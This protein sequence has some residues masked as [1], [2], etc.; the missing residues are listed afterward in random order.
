MLNVL[1]SAYACEPGKGSEPGVGWNH[2]CQIAR[3]NKVWVLTRSSNRA[4]IE[5]AQRAEPVPNLNLIYYDLPKWI[6]FWKKG[7]RGLGLYYYLWQMLSVRE[8]RRHHGRVKFDV[9]HH[10]TFVTYW[11][12][13]FLHYLSIPFIWGPVGGGE[14][15]PASFIPSFG[16]RGMLYELLRAGARLLGELDPFVRRAGRRSSVALATTEQTAERLRKLGCQTVSIASEAGL[17]SRDLA[18]LLEIPPPES[19]PFRVLTVGRLLH[20]K[21]MEFALR[22]FHQFRHQYGEAQHWIV[23]EGPEREALERLTVELGL[24]GSVSFFGRLPRQE[25]LDKLRDCDALLFPSFHDSGGWVCLEAMAAGRPVICLDL[26]GPGLQVTPETG[27]KVAAIN[28][29]QVVS[30]LSDAL[31]KIARDPSLAQELGANGRAR[32]EREFSWERKGEH[33]ASLYAELVGT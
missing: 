13:T 33:L 1:L 8:A 23:G 2:A 20:W 4:E 19:K 16:W 7:E 17:S 29:Q 6:S 26:G 28:P 9:A 5:K 21:G 27:I 3:F 11:R 25:A 31:L 15:A 22:A 30:D 24:Q 14:S 10:V 18:E 32:V 12:P